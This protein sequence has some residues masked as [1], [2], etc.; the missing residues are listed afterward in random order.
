MLHNHTGRS[1]VAGFAAKFFA[2]EI[3][4]WSGQEPLWKV[5]WGYGVVTSAI[6]AT[7]YAAASYIEQIALQQILL[8][9]FAGYTVW[10]LISAWRCAKNTKEDFWGLLARL[11]IVAWAANTIMILIFL[12]LDLVIKYF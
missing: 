8:L 3:R 10:I 4:S 11:L 1:I 7:F 12:Q 5:F 9:C 2:M 6:I